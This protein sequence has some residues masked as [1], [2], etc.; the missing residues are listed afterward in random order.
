[1]TSLG[2]N[3]DHSIN[4]AGGG[5][6]VF[7]I[8]GALHHRSG[9]LIPRVGEDPVYAQLYIYDPQEAL[10]FRMNNEN[11]TALNRRVMSDLQDMLHRHHPAV[12]L[13]KQALEL[14]RTMGPDQQCKI[15]LQFDESKDQR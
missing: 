6:Y 7:K 15:A 11:N 8:K 1:M 9:S 4:R 5:P 3:Q 14:T 13:Y 12:L 10:D 2:C